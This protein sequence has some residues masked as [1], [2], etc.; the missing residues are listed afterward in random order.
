MEGG[1]EVGREDGGGEGREKEGEREGEPLTTV[2]LRGISQVR[3]MVETCFLLYSFLYHQ[4]LY[5]VHTSFFQ[6]KNTFKKKKHG[7]IEK[8]SS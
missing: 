3:Y 1:R 8:Q 7:Q 4:V 6:F 5:Q 2:S